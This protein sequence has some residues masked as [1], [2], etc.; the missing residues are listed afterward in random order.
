MAVFQKTYFD[1][2]LFFQA[3]GGVGGID[4]DC[5]RPVFISDKT[6]GRFSLADPGSVYQLCLFAG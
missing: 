1:I 4:H 3:P 5:H 2:L 6:I